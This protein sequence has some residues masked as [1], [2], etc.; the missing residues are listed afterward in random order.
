MSAFVPGGTFVIPPTG[1]GPLN[2][3]TFAV[4]DLID[5]AGHVTGGGNPDWA[6]AQQPAKHHAPVVERMLAAGATLIGKTITDELAFSLEGENAHF[7][8]PLNPRRPDRL[9]GG[10]SSG[11]ASAVAASLADLA[12]GT[13]TGGSVRVPASFCGLFG[14]R[15]SHGRLPLDGVIPFAPSYDT[16]GLFARDADTLQRGALALL[17]D[18]A[19]AIPITRV[20]WASDAYA[21]AEPA[22]AAALPRLGDAVRLYEGEDIDWLE[23]YR[24]LQAAD[25]QSSLGPWIATAKPHFGDNI[26]PR[27]NDALA[28][29]ETEIKRYRP[30]RAAIKAK[31]EA[32]LPPGTVLLLP[33]APGPALKRDS[34]GAARGDFYRRALTLTSAA[35]HAGLPVLSIPVAEIDSCPIGLSLMG[36]AG[37]DEALLD[38]ALVAPL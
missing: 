10:S 34:D 31:L 7:G 11:S 4:K 23:A 3:R 37:Q 16:V 38:F 6:A 8:I 28:V 33:T 25:I 15:P 20:M 18:T 26:A 19:P 12:L 13:D 32:M 27:F 29:S 2:G 14:Y 9:P 17:V 36:S 24:V 5:I 1:A 35:G 21:M 22:V 30:I